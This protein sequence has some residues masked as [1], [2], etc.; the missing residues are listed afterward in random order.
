MKPD[1]KE[2]TL[3]NVGVE[4]DEESWVIFNVNSLGNLILHT[5]MYI[6]IIKTKK[7]IK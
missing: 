2:T 1:E 3:N 5:Y 7:F 6:Y 4:G